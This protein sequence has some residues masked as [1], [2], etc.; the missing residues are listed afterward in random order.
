LGIVALSVTFLFPIT[1]IVYQILVFS[2]IT[3]ALPGGIMF[4]RLSMQFY[5]GSRMIVSKIQGKENPV[6]EQNLHQLS[7]KFVVLTV[8]VI[9]LFYGII[10]LPYFRE[11]VDSRGI[12]IIIVTTIPCGAIDTAAGTLLVLSI[13]FTKDAIKNL[14]II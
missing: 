14:H 8:F 6:C 11:Q 10:E 1:P 5:A 2:Q 3:W 13:F 12:W 7:N 9:A 4:I